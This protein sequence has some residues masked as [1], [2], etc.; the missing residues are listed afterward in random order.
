MRIDD[1]ARL[2]RRQNISINHQINQIVGSNAIVRNQS[3]PVRIYVPSGWRPWRIE[4]V[5]VQ[6]ASALALLSFGLITAVI[7]GI[8]P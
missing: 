8:V 3:D 5:S 6:V 2:A 4:M 7:I 1:V